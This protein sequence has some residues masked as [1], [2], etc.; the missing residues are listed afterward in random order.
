MPLVP[1]AWLA[2]HVDVT[3]SAEDVAAALVKVG[4][5][6]EAIHGGDITGPLVVGRVLDITV[7]PQKSGKMIRWTHVDVGEHNPT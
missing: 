6:E 5:E 4:L 3:G 1:L 2:E 7:E